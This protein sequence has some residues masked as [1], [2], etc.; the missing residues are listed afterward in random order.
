MEIDRLSGAVLPECRELPRIYRRRIR[1]DFF[2]G[3][4]DCDQ[5]LERE[6][7][8]R[9]LFSAVTPVNPLQ[10]LLAGDL[11]RAAQFD[12]LIGKLILRQDP[13]QTGD[14]VFERDWLH[15]R[16]PIARQ[17]HEWAARQF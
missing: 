10:E 3:R 9:R 1:E 14:D 16:P 8:Y 13:S 12:N 11:F 5:R 7:K 2:Q 15:S 6:V 17:S 4:K